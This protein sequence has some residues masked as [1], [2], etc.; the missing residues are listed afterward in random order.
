M[1]ERFIKNEQLNFIKKQIA[2]IKDSAKKN[3]PLQLWPQ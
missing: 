3:V 1:T 2:Y